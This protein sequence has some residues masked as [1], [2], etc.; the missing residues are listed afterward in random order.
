MSTR[1]VEYSGCWSRGVRQGYG[2]Q[3]HANVDIKQ[4]EWKNNM[5][6]G[7]GVATMASGSKYTG[8]LIDDAPNGRG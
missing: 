4:G 5:F 3:K 1:V 7:K 8:D 2:T 6:S